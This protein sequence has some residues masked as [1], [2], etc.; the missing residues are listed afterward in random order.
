MS[1]PRELAEFL[2]FQQQMPMSDALPYPVMPGQQYAAGTTPSSIQMRTIR[3]LEDLR[4]Q[5]GVQASTPGGRDTDA[6]L[7]AIEEALRYAPK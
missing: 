1:D 7:K 3:Q 4:R 2:M 5:M 6:A